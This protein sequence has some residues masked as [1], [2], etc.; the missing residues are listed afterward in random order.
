ML[1][2]NSAHAW[3]A[4]GYVSIFQSE[5]DPSNRS[6]RTR[7]AAEPTPIHSAISLQVGWPPLIWV[8]RSHDVTRFQPRPRLPRSRTVPTA[9]VW[10]AVFDHNAGVKL[11]SE[12]DHF[13]HPLKPPHYLLILTLSLHAP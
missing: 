4:R 7:S 1:N 5:P 9:P 2:P 8:S 12:P 3:M 10:R 6:V 13:F 11:L